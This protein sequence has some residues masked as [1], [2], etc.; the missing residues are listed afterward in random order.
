MPAAVIVT[1]S[2]QSSNLA[3]PITAGAGSS[4][5]S[6]R[7]LYSVTSSSPIVAHAPGTRSLPRI[8][9]CNF[10]AESMEFHLI[11]ATFALFFQIGSYVAPSSVCVTFVYVPDAIIAT[12]SLIAL[13]PSGNMNRSY[14]VETV[15]FGSTATSLVRSNG[16]VSSPSSAKNIENPPFTSP[17]ISVQLMA[18]APR[19]RGSNDG[20]YTIDPCFGVSITSIGMNCVTKARTLRS[21]LQP[22]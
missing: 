12:A 5:P 6:R 7:E 18:D 13:I 8:K 3:S 17:S 21:G 22:W 9:L 16:P 2:S 1:G 20:W 19:C 15:S 4:G 10:A 11:P 14:R